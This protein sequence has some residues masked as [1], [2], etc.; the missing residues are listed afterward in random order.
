MVNMLIHAKAVSAYTAEEH[1][2]VD[3]GMEVKE[4][5]HALP[6]LL[7]SSEPHTFVYIDLLHTAIVWAWTEPPSR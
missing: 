2:H 3:S 7:F 1:N 6:F 4:A 5:R